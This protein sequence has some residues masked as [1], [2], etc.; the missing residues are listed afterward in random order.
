MS[1]IKSRAP[2]GTML[3]FCAVIAGGCPSPAVKV[4]PAARG[5]WADT[6]ARSMDVER[7]VRYYT[8]EQGM[9]WDD[10]GRNHGRR[11]P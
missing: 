7:E 1:P 10:R 2:L 5:T 8:D 11:A 3:A 4:A 9:V 6:P